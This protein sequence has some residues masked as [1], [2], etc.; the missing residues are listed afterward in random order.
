MDYIIANKK[1]EGYN[2]PGRA[3]LMKG[4][5]TD[6]RNYLE[7]MEFMWSVDENEGFKNNDGFDKRSLENNHNS[8]ENGQFS[9]S[10]SVAHI[11]RFCEKYDKVMYVA[12]H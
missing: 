7:G 4:L 8:E 2:N 6:S 12:K 5:V 3:S 10:I 11:F 1:I 9:A